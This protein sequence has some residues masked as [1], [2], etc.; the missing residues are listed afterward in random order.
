MEHH[1][2]GLKPLE[3]VD[4]GAQVLGRCGMRDRSGMRRE[5]FGAS[6]GSDPDD[7]E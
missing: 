6:K 4:E 3:W 2:G 1:Q 7:D 5:M